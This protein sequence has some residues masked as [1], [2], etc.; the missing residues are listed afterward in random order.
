MSSDGDTRSLRCDDTEGAAGLA[1]A[2]VE[3]FRQLAMMAE[4]REGETP[5]HIERVSATAAGIATR[6]GLDAEQVALMSEAAALHDV[7][8]LAIPDTILLKPN[9][10]TEQEY[11]LVKTHAMLGAHLLS[12]SSSPVLQLAAVIAASHHER[13]DGTGYPA[14]LAGEAIPLPGRVVAVAD[15]FDAL[16]HD[17]PYK[18][19]WPAEQAIAEI[20]R[21]AASQFDQ[22]VVA[23]FLDMQGDEAFAA[24]GG[25][26]RLFASSLR[27]PRRRRGVASSP[28]SRPA[29]R[30]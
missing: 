15:V 6:L 25:E 23:A 22:L 8:K 26:S 28:P 9:K 30:A 4:Y 7:G 18:S 21:G 16:I 29:G 11:E 5:Q 27:P 14:G 19:L 3:A 10:L 12:E 1:A 24:D 13:W 17:R 2:R 20:R